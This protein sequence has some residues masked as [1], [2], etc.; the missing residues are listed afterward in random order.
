FRSSEAVS[1]YGA[2]SKLIVLVATPTIIFSGVIPPLVAELYAKGKVRQLE[3][4]L[5]VGATLVGVPALLVLVLFIV[6]GPWVM[7]TVF[8]PFYT[9][10]ASFLVIKS[11]GRVF[12]VW[13]GSSGIALMMT[14][15][16]KDMM[17]TTILG[18]TLSVG[19]GL[20][21]TPHFGAT[22]IAVTTAAAQVVQN[23]A[24]LILAHRRLGIWTF[25]TMSP[26]TIRDILFGQRGAKKGDDEKEPSTDGG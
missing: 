26:R 16:Q 12:A 15:H 20:L 10:G 18:A 23:L 22:G 8:G 11:I 5:R 25:V 19:G 7:S 14:G 2:S 24:Q 6:A 13:T 4:T 21:V 3:R 1:L 17:R 9:A